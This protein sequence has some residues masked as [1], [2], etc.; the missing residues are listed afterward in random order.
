MPAFPLVGPQYVLLRVCKGVQVTRHL[1]T[2]LQQVFSFTGAEAAFTG[3]NSL[4]LGHV[5]AVPAAVIGLV[6]AHVATCGGMIHPG[7][8]ITDCACMCVTFKDTKNEMATKWQT[9]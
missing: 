5:N 4:L 1:H 7:I 3:S 6:S 8:S 9:C 2:L